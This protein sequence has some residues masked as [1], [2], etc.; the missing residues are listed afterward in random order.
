LLLREK[1]II[2]AQKIN[3]D[4]HVFRCQPG[5]ERSPVI[6]AFQI[7]VWCEGSPCFLVHFPV[8]GKHIVPL[9]QDLAIVGHSDINAG[10]GPAGTPRRGSSGSLCGAGRGQQCHSGSILKYAS[11]HIGERAEGPKEIVIV[12]KI[13][14]TSVGKVFKPALR[15]DATKRVY[16]DELA[17]PAQGQ[18]P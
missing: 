4:R 2:F 12:D 15:W 6:P 10:K 3:P 18:H 8:T 5:S 17:A 1:Y 9:D 16:A 14:Q 11:E 7:A 13:P